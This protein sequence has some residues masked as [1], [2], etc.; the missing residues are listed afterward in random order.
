MF[1]SK[2]SILVN[3]CDSYSDC[4]MPFFY[5]FSLFGDELKKCRIYLN[6]ETKGFRYPMLDIVSVQTRERDWGK[7]VRLSLGCIRTEYVL[8]FLDDFFLREKVDCEQIKRCIDYMDN[9]KNIGV[10]YF[11][12]IG[13]KELQ[14]SK[15]L[16]FCKLPTFTP[17]RC[18]TQAAIWRRD[19]LLASILDIESPWEWEQYGTLRN[20]YILK[21]TEFY[22]LL[23]HSKTPINYGLS[24][25]KDFGIVQGKWL[26]SDIEPLF[27]KY[28]INVDLSI[29]G[30][31]EEKKYVD[32]TAA[33]LTK[34]SVLK[35]FLSYIYRPFR[36]HFLYIKYSKA[37]SQK[38]RLFCA[39]VLD[40]IRNKNKNKSW[41]TIDYKHR[42][43][44]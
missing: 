30:F 34:K 7:R 22:A 2:V 27:S 18:N 23:N 11:D 24:K 43:G 42:R 37:T 31:A 20:Y 4:W 6:S 16:G 3:T 39:L 15:Y 36:L 38:E 26:K 13:K 19:V 1:K 9:N 40:P 29:R 32:N 17:W 28:G 44:L 5:F 33:P 25:V 14:S 35:R 8:E 12:P 41:N 21:N 10:F